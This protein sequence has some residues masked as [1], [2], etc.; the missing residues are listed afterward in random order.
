[1]SRVTLFRCDW[2]GS[3]AKEDWSAATTSTCVSRMTRNNATQRAGYSRLMEEREE[4][5]EHCNK[6]LEIL[7]DRIRETAKGNAPD[8]SKVLAVQGVI[9][10]T[11]AGPRDLS[12]K[13]FADLF[14]Y[15][16]VRE[17]PLD[18]AHYIIE[19]RESSS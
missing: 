18:S 8:V 4:V 17:E 19:P 9:V 12:L 2:C 14:T 13:E 16:D 3:E 6:A 5:C 7:R 1:M 15:R 10:R 11:E